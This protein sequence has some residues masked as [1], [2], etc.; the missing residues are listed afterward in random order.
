MSICYSASQ[1]NC[2]QRILFCA[3]TM[4]F[5][6]RGFTL[7]LNSYYTF[8]LYIFPVVYLNVKLLIFPIE[9]P[10]TVPN[11]RSNDQNNVQLHYK[12]QLQYMQ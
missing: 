3:F 8:L 1:V 6:K 9:N 4:H 7:Q 2:S 5:L 11:F 12:P 10:N